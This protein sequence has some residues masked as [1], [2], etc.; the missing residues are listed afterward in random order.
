[1]AY[2]PSEN[3]A[4]ELFEQLMQLDL[5]DGGEAQKKAKYELIDDIAEARF[6][7]ARPYARNIQ[8]PR[9]RNGMNDLATACLDNKE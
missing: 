3:E 2:P 8:H 7:E 1:M 6:F 5:L 9:T 4:R